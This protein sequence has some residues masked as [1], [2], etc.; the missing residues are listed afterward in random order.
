M[1]GK[2][3]QF[4]SESFNAYIDWCIGVP[5]TQPENTSQ[6]P[7]PISIRPVPHFDFSL[8]QARS[9]E[10]YGTFR[11]EDYLSKRLKNNESIAFWGSCSIFKTTACQ[12]FYNAEKLTDTQF[13]NHIV[14]YHDKQLLIFLDNSTPPGSAGSHWQVYVLNKADY[15]LYKFDGL[16]WSARSDVVAEIKNHIKKLWPEDIREIEYSPVDIPKQPNHWDCGPAVCWIVDQMAS[17]GFQ[18]LL[19]WVKSYPGTQYDYGAFRASVDALIG[20]EP[21][22]SSSRTP[23]IFSSAAGTAE[24][25][26]SLDSDEEDLFRDMGE[27]RRTRYTT[28]GNASNPICIDSDSDSDERCTKRHKH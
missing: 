23:V 27:K 18:A 2:A 6:P 20:P 10:W 13:W 4:L 1:W 21:L 7:A 26:I 14:P 5:S 11:I 12:K 16:N 22:V 9:T 3:F 8:S 28:N 25:P 19:Q 17:H 24:D 15:K